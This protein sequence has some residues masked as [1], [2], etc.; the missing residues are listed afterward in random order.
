MRGAVLAAVLGDLEAAHL[1]VALVN[2][3]RWCR[4]QG[5]AMP[6]ALAAL[7]DGL[8]A[9]SGPERPEVDRGGA[10]PDAALMTYEGAA[11]VLDCSGRTVRRLVRSGRLPAVRIGRAVRIRVGDVEALHR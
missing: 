8:T 2:H 5:V 9:R 4:T 11:R 1:K 7:L 3:R 6:E 10:R